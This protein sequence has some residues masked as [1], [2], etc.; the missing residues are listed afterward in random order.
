MKRAHEP[1]R[2]ETGWDTD[3]C[4]FYI[5]L[6]IY[7]W[8]DNDEPVIERVELLKLEDYDSLGNIVDSRDRCVIPERERRTYDAL[9]LDQVNQALHD[10]N[11]TLQEDLSEHAA[12]EGA[13]R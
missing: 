3:D 5:E 9:L 12:S 8:P 13:G 6:A 4:L 2:F 7:Y 10:V 1:L 11:N